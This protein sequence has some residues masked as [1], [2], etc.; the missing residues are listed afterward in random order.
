VELTTTDNVNSPMGC[1]FSPDLALVHAC[2][3][4]DI[5]AFEQLIKRYEVRLFSIAQ[6]ITIARMRGMPFRKPF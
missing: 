2:K 1:S 6:H 5:A 4:G 3:N